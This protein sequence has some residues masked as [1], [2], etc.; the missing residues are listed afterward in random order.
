MESILHALYK[1]SIAL[2]NLMSTV[3]LEPNDLGYV[4]TFVSAV[5]SGTFVVRVKSVF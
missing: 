5:W 3:F 1:R 4:H 2:K